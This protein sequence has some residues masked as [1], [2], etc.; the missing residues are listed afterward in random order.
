[1]VLDLPGLGLEGVVSFLF[2]REGV[3]YLIDLIN[4]LI[5]FLIL[6]SKRVALDYL[7]HLYQELVEISYVRRNR[8]F[9]AHIQEFLLFL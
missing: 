2:R 7:Q 5:A 8:V 4:D 6:Q 3:Y 9:E 1:M